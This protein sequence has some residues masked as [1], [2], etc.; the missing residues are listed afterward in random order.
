MG[1]TTER[2]QLQ[3]E[4]HRVRDELLGSPWSCPH[5]VDMTLTSIRETLRTEL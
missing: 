5:R 3:K 1:N 4:A 2:T